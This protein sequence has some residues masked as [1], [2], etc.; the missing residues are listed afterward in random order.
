MSL[1][2]DWR[3]EE[4]VSEQTLQSEA[5]AEPVLF[6]PKHFWISLRQPEEGDWPPAFLTRRPL[7]DPEHL[8][9]V[10][11]SGPLTGNYAVA[12]WEA[13]RA[14]L[15]QIYGELKAKL[16]HEGFDAMVK[17]ALGHPDPGND[18]PHDLA[19]LQERLNSNDLETV[20]T[21]TKDINNDLYMTVRAFCRLMAISVNAQADDYE[22]TAKEWEEVYTI[23]RSAQK[24]KREYPAWISEEEQLPIIDPDVLKL[25]DLPEPTAGKRAIALW[26]ARR[27][28]LDGNYEKLRAKRE[29]EGF[30]TMLC[31]AIGAPPVG[32]L[33]SYYLGE[34]R[35]KLQSEDDDQISEAKI[36]IAHVLFMTV[37]DFTRLMEVKAK[38]SADDA[39]N[40]P[41]DNEWDEV[42]TILTQAQ[43]FKQAYPQWVEEERGLDYWDMLKAKRPP[44][45][46][47]PVK[48]PPRIRRR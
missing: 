11:L 26:A 48:R 24:L 40:K 43:K 41:T 33:W 17:W 12:L 30:E 4:R 32:D 39:Q 16:E 31:E 9:P 36:T 19:E 29:T 37:D 15:D 7:I 23:L 5:Q 22:P 3:E 21:A 42:Y 27:E 44:H 6:S 20:K 34:I 18:L 14:R 38:D 46:V 13:R 47:R 35:D 8:D 1:F 28:Q 10:E 2:S 25:V 45:R